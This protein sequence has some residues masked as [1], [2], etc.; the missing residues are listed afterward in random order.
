MSPNNHQERIDHN[1]S[2]PMSKTRTRSRF[3]D[4]GNAE[5]P[6]KDAIKFSLI[7]F[8]AASLAILSV[9]AFVEIAR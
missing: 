2:F 9:S 1:T 4:M 8:T 5:T 7:T 3:Y 6:L